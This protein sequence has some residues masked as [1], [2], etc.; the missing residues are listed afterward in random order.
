[1]EYHNSGQ[2]TFVEKVRRLLL[3]RHHSVHFLLQ[4]PLNH[5]YAYNLRLIQFILITLQLKDAVV[6][7]LFSIFLAACAGA[8]YVVYMTAT[9][10][11]SLS[12][13]IA[14]LMA[15]GN[16]YGILLITVLMG[17]GLVA[18]PRRIWQLGDTELELN[19]L[20]LQVSRCFLHQ[21][22]HHRLFSIFT[23]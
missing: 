9:S 13:V 5:K 14:F 4:S 18:L 16:T 3:S 6:R 8:I 23:D 20:Y 2:F 12:Q 19:R 7:N 15:M 21:P 17:N 11:A 1:M 10:Q 22:L